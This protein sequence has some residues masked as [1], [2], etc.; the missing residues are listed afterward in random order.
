MASDRMWLTHKATGKR[1]LLAKSLDGYHWEPREACHTELTGTSLTLTEALE[2]LFRIAW[3]EGE[4]A[5]KA[6]AVEYE[7]DGC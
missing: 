1:V 5:F 3:D 2:E 7:S 6:F 4:S